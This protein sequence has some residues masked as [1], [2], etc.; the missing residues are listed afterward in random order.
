MAAGGQQA[1]AQ[2][3]EHCGRNQ[4]RDERIG[5]D[6]S[7]R[8]GYSCQGD[9]FAPILAFELRKQQSNS[10]IKREISVISYRI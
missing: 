5:A 7:F 3:Q 1:E 4:N 6:V 9:I 10:N 2:Q 8:H